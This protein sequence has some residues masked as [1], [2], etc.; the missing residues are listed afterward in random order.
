MN[1][2]TGRKDDAD[3]PRYSLLPAGPLA[4]VVATLEH[5]ARK[6]APGNWVKVPD[7]RTRYFDAAQRHL[8]AW[9]GGERLDPDSGLPHLAHAGCCVLFLLHFDADGPAP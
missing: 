9:W 6:C 1:E 3:K 8:W 7:A 4:A 5:G 2:P